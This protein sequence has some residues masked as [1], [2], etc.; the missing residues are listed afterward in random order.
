MNRWTKQTWHY[1]NCIESAW[2][3]NEWTNK[4]SFQEEEIITTIWIGQK[5]RDE[6]VRIVGDILRS[7][8]T[9]TILDLSR[10]YE[11]KKQ[12]M[13]KI[14]KEIWTDNDIGAEGCRIVSEILK[15]NSTLIKV[16]LYGD[17]IEINNDRLC[18]QLNKGSFWERQL[19]RKGRWKYIGRVIEN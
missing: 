1:F 5:I 3:W 17:G 4:R 12:T 14:I 10:D 13:K 6:E 15:E 9:L 19:D 11:K 8:S 7:Y 2:W 18:V 16:N